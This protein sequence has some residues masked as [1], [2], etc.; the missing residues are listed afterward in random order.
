[1]EA[2]RRLEFEEAERLRGLLELR[3]AVPMDT[4]AA[5]VVA[6]VRKLHGT[7]PVR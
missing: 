1:M 4:V 3:Q 2:A 6:L 7:T 5:E